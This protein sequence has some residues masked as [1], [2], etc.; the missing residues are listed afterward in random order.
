MNYGRLFCEICNFDFYKKYGELGGD[1]IEG[2][3]TI[4]VS[5][6]E[7]GHKTNVKDIVLVCSNC[8]RMLHRK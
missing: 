4:P 1:F 8:H 6:L 5:E 2:H 3:H 7:E